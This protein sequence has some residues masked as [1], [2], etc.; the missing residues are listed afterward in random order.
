MELKKNV[1]KILQHIIQK[2]NILGNKTASW[3]EKNHLVYMP[4][5]CYGFILLGE[6]TIKCV[7]GCLH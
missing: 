7:G 2:S 1:Y 3:K 6:I 4:E 5:M